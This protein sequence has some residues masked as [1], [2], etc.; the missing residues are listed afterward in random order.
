MRWL[1]A[2]VSLRASAMDRDDAAAAMARARAHSKAAREAQGGAASSAGTHAHDSQHRRHYRHGEEHTRRKQRPCATD[3]CM[4]A[5]LAKVLTCYGPYASRV[6]RGPVH[7]EVVTEDAVAVYG[8]LGDADVANLGALAACVERHGPDRKPEE[9]PF[10]DQSGANLCANLNW[11][12]QR[13][14]PELADRVYAVAAAAAAGAGPAFAADPRDLE[15]RVVEK[16]TY[17]RAGR[18]DFHR[19]A[20]STYTLVLMLSDPGSDFDGGHFVA[21]HGHDAYEVDLAHFGGVLIRS[22]VPHG[23]GMVTRGKREVLAVEFWAHQ[24]ANATEHRPEPRRPG[25]RSEL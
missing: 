13:A 12:F 7:R 15:L 14:A 22:D 21:R 11:F 24:A 9:R 19:D 16:V 25:D 5:A 23:I 17:R 8:A 3:D 10:H 6:S 2:L 20:H 1:V 18:L 4:E